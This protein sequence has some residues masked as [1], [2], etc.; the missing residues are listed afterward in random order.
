MGLTKEIRAA[1]KQVASDCCKFLTASPSPFHAV[2][3]MTTELK[4]MGFKQLFEDDK[5]HGALEANG[6]YFTT[7]NQSSLIAFVVGGKYPATT[8]GGGFKIVGAHTDS[9]CFVLKPKTA[10]Q[11]SGYKQVGVQTYGGGLWHTWFD[12]DVA[13]AGK[14]VYRGED[15]S[16]QSKLLKVDR[17]ILR[18]PNLAIHLTNAKERE[19]FTFNK[20]QHLLP[21]LCSDI[22]SQL[23]AAEVKDEEKEDAKSSAKPRHHAELLNLIAEET[24]VDVKALVDFDLY[25]YDTQEAAVGGL[26]EEFVF[27]ARID[28]LISC[29]NGVE[30]LK[31]YCQDG[32][33]IAEDSMVS[34]LAVYDHE[35]VGSASAIGAGSSFTNDVIRRVTSVFSPH[36][37]AYEQTIRSSFVASVDGVHGVHPNYSD[38]HQMNHRPEMHKGPTIKYN[39]NQRYATNSESSSIV[40]RL[41]ELVA[42]PTQEV[43]VK[44]DSPCGSTIGPIISTGTGITTVDIGNPMLSMHSVREQCGTIDLHYMN[45]LLHSFYKNYSEVRKNLPRF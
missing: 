8:G 24:G 36:A 12:R 26:F 41:A 39:A 4:K 31:A 43:C 35:E 21:M 23:E 33:S 25:L 9:P 3:N 18:I 2:Q 14:V 34:M 5:W 16:L 37:D 28:N 13:I 6:R 45:L 20:E 29:Y 1:S 7:R 19:A 32:T 44:N 11:S 10:E 27:S 17:P 42:V 30:A 22:V 15:G 38:R 40:K